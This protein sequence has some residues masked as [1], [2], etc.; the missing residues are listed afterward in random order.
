MI[1]IPMRTLPPFD[2]E[3]ILSINQKCVQGA[4]SSRDFISASCLS[5]DR[6][7]APA[8]GV[9]GGSIPHVPRSSGSA[10]RPVPRPSGGSVSSASRSSGSMV[11][12]AV[13][14]VP[15]FSG[16]AVPQLLRPARKGQK[17]SLETSRR[18]SSVQARLGWTAVNP[19]CDVDV[20]A[21]LLNNTGKVIGDSWFVFYGQDV[22]PDGSTRFSVEQ[23]AVRESITI[24]FR[25]LSPAVSRI[26]FV[27]T[28][29]EALEKHLNFSML[30][31]AY[32]QIVDSSDGTELVS[33][34]M[35][36]YYSNVT[37]MM[38]GEVYQHNGMWKFNAIGNGVAR[39][40]AGLCELYGVQVV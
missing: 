28:I 12:P 14:S 22:S 34:M 38:I 29:N 30:R 5:S 7:A 2:R 8:P 26:V 16:S 33:F 21:F 13:S 37:S 24:D 27:L 19:E 6:A 1:N 35:T 40:L 32:I 17:V 18:V 10:A 23:G 11:R 36:E 25:K 9:S 39:D 31:D 15:R 3:T 20:S 4:R